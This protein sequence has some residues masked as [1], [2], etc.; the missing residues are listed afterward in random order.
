MLFNS[1]KQ[2]KVKIGLWIDLTNTSRKDFEC[3][4]FQF[5]SFFLSI[6]LLAIAI[7]LS[8]FSSICLLLYYS[9]FLYLSFPLSLCLCFSWPVYLYDFLSFF[10][11][12]IPRSG[13]TFLKPLIV[14]LILSIYNLSVS[15][16]LST[17][18]FRVNW[19]NSVTGVIP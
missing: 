3:V 7:F 5:F 4:S 2:H 12:W 11:T 13:D 15:F 8:L 10:L 16:P 6:R 1:M 9:N 14:F 18:L 17:Y 19:G